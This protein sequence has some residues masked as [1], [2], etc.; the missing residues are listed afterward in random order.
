MPKTIK[1]ESAV[2][3]PIKQ[4]GPDCTY[5]IC[6]LEGK[7]VALIYTT[8]ESGYRVRIINPD[9]DAEVIDVAVNSDRKSYGPTRFAKMAGVMVE[10]VFFGRLDLDLAEI[11]NWSV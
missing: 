4:I 5:Y 8:A 11:P 10:W 2:R 6:R 7:P 9:R 1:I 3:G